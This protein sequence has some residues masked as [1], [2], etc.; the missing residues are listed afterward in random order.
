MEINLESNKAVPPEVRGWNWGAFLLTWIWGICNGTFLALLSLI[1]GVHFIM[2]FVLGAKGNEWAWKNKQWDSVEQFHKAQRRWAIWAVSLWLIG[3]SAAVLFTVGILT[4]G[5]QMEMPEIKKVMKD[6]DPHRNYTNYALEEASRNPRLNEYFGENLHVDGAVQVSGI[7][8]GYSEVQV[9]VRGARN[10]GKIYLRVRHN[11]QATE[12]R[13]KT[14]LE[15]AE[16][17]LQNL[18]RVKINTEASEERIRSA[19]KKVASIICATRKQILFSG[20]EPSTAEEAVEFF[21]AAMDKVEADPQVKSA[22]GDHIATYM[23][24]ADVDLE[25]PIGVADYHIL[26]KGNG[27]EGLLDLRGTRSMGRWQIEGASLDMEGRTISFPYKEI[28][29]AR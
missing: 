27:K 13:L 16:V 15:K 28:E 7:K 1:P 11:L 22:L 21:R 25:G 2:M 10:S 18:E 26:M 24:K 29:P 4:M 3:A 6:F 20:R 8:N 14:K 17:E 12:E 9:P 23:K 19:E 5:V